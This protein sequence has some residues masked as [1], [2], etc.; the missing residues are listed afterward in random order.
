M[1]PINDWH[2]LYLEIYEENKKLKD[3]NK[4][5][6]NDNLRYEQIIQKLEKE[7]KVMRKSRD[8]WKKLRETLDILYDEQKKELEDLK[9]KFQEYCGALPKEQNK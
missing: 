2:R 5:M 4:E 9:E 3:V 8:S 6:F 1:K 7:I